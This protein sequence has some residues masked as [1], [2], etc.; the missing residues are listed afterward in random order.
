M[1]SRR[2]HHSKD[3]NKDND[4]SDFYK[5]YEEMNRAEKKREQKIEKREKQYGHDAP[6]WSHLDESGKLLD[7]CDWFIKLP[8]DQ[9]MEKLYQTQNQFFKIMAQMRECEKGSAKHRDL[10]EKLVAKN[11]VIDHLQNLLNG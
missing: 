7:Q 11:L 10:K 4:N 5:Q 3:S 9:L 2:S 8:H 1:S 6:I